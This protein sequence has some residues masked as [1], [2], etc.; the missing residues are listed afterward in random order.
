MCCFFCCADCFGCA[1]YAGCSGCTCYTGS[2]GGADCAGCADIAGYSG[3]A[4][5]AGKSQGLYHYPG[6]MVGI[7]YVVYEP[8][9]PQKTFFDHTSHPSQWDSHATLYD[10]YY[11]R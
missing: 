3:Y 2:V 8:T 7:W 11:H 6:V 1:D 9:I 5:Y 10:Q 4:G